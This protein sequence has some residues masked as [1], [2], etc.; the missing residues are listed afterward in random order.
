LSTYDPEQTGNYY[1]LGDSQA[2][3]VQLIESDRYFTRSMGGLLPEQPEE[4]IANMH[5]ALDIACGPGGWVLG[6]AQAFPYIEVTGLDISQGMIDYATTLARSS[7]LDNVQFR[8]G[9]AIDP[10]D[11]P[12]DSFDLV[13]SRQIEEVIPLA[14][15]PALLKEML[16]ITRPGGIIRIS[17]NEW[18]MTN[19]PAYETLLTQ[20][21]Q[22]GLNFALH[23][24]PDAR[25]T[26]ITNMASR[27]LKDA[28]CV[29]VQERPSFMDISS[30]AEQHMDAYKMWMIAAELLE[31]FL[32][33]AGVTTK[34]MHEQL[35]HQLSQEM[36]E[37][38]FRGIIYTMTA[39][40]YKP[41]K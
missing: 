15:W 4:V 33:S 22:G 3:M 16:R 24:A 31:P 27:Y 6:M 40:G 9:S 21:N 34:S 2:E 36:T 1:L 12:D 8:V 10:L 11:F 7:Q 23:H 37:D 18:G 20:L 28:G 25:T 41:E 17:G 19:S 35:K 32:L 26:G 30:G 39:W 5:D 14:S 29:N 13:N 38:S